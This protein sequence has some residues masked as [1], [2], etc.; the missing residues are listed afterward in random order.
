[1]SNTSK[2]F[3]KYLKGF[4]E[5]TLKLC[6]DELKRNPETYSK[7][8]KKPLFKND[9]FSNIEETT[10]LDYSKLIYNIQNEIKKYPQINSLLTITKNIFKKQ[11]QELETRKKLKLDINSELLTD[12]QIFNFALKYV[13][14]NSINYDKNK[15]N[16]LL[17]KFYHFVEEDFYYSYYLTPLYNFEGD[18]AKILL[19]ENKWIRKISD[20]E[21]SKIVHLD[22]I[23]IKEIPSYQRRL[24]YV[25]VTRILKEKDVNHAQIAFENFEL[26]I[27]SLQLH[28]N[29]N[30]QFGN[31]YWI[32]SEEW[33]LGRPELVE[34]RPPPSSSKK[35]IMKSELKKTFIPFSKDLDKKLLE[36]K[37]P[38]FLKASIRRFG[39]GMN[40]RNFVDT[41]VDYVISLESLLIPSIGDSTLKIAH[42]TASLLGESDKERLAI[43]LFMKESYK[44]RSGVLHQSKERDFKL[45]SLKF[46]LESV[47][48]ILESYTKKTI[49]RMIILL[50]QFKTQDEIID[51]LDMAIYDREILKNIKKLF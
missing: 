5:S 35:Y 46:D 40:E 22:N 31:L 34:R 3:D 6:D 1:M 36:I 16:T 23:P 43:W 33:N 28:G 24:R 20:L 2:H 45:G 47:S 49:N 25:M 42:R 12:E 48:E 32:S 17:K 50:G 41:I 11:I 7:I 8:I 14:K 51:A 38:D 9:R 19:S 30:A 37:K 10:I 4:L 13:E 15:F 26:I 44:F 21:F 39:K 18:F 27:N 29:G